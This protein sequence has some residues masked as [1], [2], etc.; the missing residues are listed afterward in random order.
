MVWCVQPNYISWVLIARWFQKGAQDR[1]ILGYGIW[2][3]TVDTT[4][5]HV[6]WDKQESYKLAYSRIPSLSLLKYKASLLISWT[7]LLQSIISRQL[8]VRFGLTSHLSKILH[9]SGRSLIVPV[10]ISHPSELG[11]K[12]CKPP[13]S[14]LWTLKNISPYLKSP[15]RCEE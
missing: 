5:V 13:V 11:T 15:D 7:S 9:V 4:I 14:D 12:E 6:A 3:D 2:T 10:R 1:F 8:K